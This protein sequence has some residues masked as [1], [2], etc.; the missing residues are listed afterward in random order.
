MR[1]GTVARGRTVIAPHA[2]RRQTIINAEGKPIEIPEATEYGPGAEVE[3]P[4]DEI[5]SLRLSGFLIDPGAADV[6]RSEGPT[7]GREGQP[8]RIDAGE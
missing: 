5:K 3:L 4:A 8:S 2:T 6:P 1:R 7:F